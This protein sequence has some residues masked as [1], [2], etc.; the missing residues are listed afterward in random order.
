MS[1]EEQVFGAVF[2]TG[3]QSIA[4]PIP[5]GIDFSSASF[6]Q[7]QLLTGE[8]SCYY[9]YTIVLYLMA[10]PPNEDRH[11]LGHVVISSN[12]SHW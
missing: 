8:N 6:V 4:G 7:T 5:R 9:M 2:L 3:V 11:A 1:Q 12:L 10:R